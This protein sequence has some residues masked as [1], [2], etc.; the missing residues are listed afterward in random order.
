M[1]QPQSAIGGNVKIIGLTAEV[2]AEGQV[3]VMHVATPDGQQQRV[4]VLPEQF[5]VLSELFQVQPPVQP[6]YAPQP[7]YTPQ[8]DVFVTPQRQVNPAPQRPA[9]QP[10]PQQP[11]M[12]MPI[13]GIEA[14]A[15]V[16]RNQQT[17]TLQQADDD[18]APVDD[19]EVPLRGGLGNVPQI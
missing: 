6:Q 12:Q 11:Q 16:L 8:D 4:P 17:M 1:W 15:D 3:Y 5:E 10:A 19:G 2:T 13:S 7:Q 18:G 14:V 9:P